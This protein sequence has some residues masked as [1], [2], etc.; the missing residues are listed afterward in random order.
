[1]MQARAG[2]EPRLTSAIPLLT[3]P[4]E[5]KLVFYLGSFFKKPIS[6]ALKQTLGS[7]RKL[8]IIVTLTDYKMFF[9]K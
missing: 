6:L 9:P 8:A 4:T 3:R 7:T 2:F 5:R 1:M